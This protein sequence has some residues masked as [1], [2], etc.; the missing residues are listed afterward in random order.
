MTDLGLA[1]FI[2][3]V[4]E[5]MLNQSQSAVVNPLSCAGIVP[6]PPGTEMMRM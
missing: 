3:D 5:E 4:R 1:V 2:A 6:E